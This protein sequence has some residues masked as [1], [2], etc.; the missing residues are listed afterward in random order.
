MDINQEKSIR[1]IRSGGYGEKWSQEEEAILKEKCEQKVFLKDIAK[2]LKKSKSACIGKI[3]RMG[4]NFT[5]D[6]RRIWKAEE[7]ERLKKLCKQNIQSEKIAKMLNKTT[8]ACRNKMSGLGIRKPFSYKRYS[9][10]ENFWVPNSTSCYFAG[11]SAADASLS[12]ERSK[13]E[14]KI[15]INK[16]DI[17]LLYNFKENSLFTGPVKLRPFS[18]HSGEMC[19]VCVH[20]KRWFSDLNKYYN[21]TP[22]K[23]FTLQ[24]PNLD[25]FYLKLCFLIGFIDGDGSICSTEMGKNISI[26][27]VGASYPIIK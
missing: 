6:V 16:K 9:H 20:S 12:F 25:D 23:T 26:K 11:F 22:R 8:S 10:N 14:F 2:I 1:K 5:P 7:V 24:P 21:I 15:A 3:I 4:L 27:A 17:S 13:Y 19:C 18:V